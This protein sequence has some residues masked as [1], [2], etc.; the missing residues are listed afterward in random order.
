MIDVC[1]L[2]DITKQHVLGGNNPETTKEAQKIF[3]LCIGVLQLHEYLQTIPHERI[4][5]E[6]VIKQILA[7]YLKQ[8]YEKELNNA[9][10]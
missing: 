6:T 9:A 1:L 10:K 4:G 3:Y 5:S 7:E 2:I 8:I